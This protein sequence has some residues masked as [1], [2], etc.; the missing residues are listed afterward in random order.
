[1]LLRKSANVVVI[2][3]IRLNVQLRVNYQQKELNWACGMSL[4][5]NEPRPES[6]YGYACH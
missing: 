1:M 4:S 5:H 2:H 6:R 3:M